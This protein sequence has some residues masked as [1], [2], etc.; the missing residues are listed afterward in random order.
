MTQ[1]PASLQK[2][3]LIAIVAPAKAIE[4]EHVL[5]AKSFFEKEGF[6]VEVS[7]NC[8]GSYN[9][10]SGDIA[11]RLR[12]FQ[13]ELDH[14]E[15]KA[16]IC[17]R[18][19]YG[20]VQLLDR[21]Q[22]AS[23]LREPKW[24]VGFS[25]VTYFHQRMQMHGI[26]SIHG[27]M[28]LNFKENSKEALSTLINCLE[29]KPSEISWERNSYNR[30]G[31]TSGKLVG[32]NLS[33]LYALLGTDDQINF[34]NTILYIEDVGEPI[35]AIDRM[36]Y[37]FS[38]AGV[39]DK[40]NGLVVGGMTSLSDT[41]VPYGNAY[42]EVVLSHFEYRKIPIAFDLPAGHIDDNRALV[43][44]KEARLDAGKDDCLLSF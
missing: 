37:A 17:A 9:Y 30:I 41:A 3:D 24:I 1:I 44:G 19:G 15:V 7:D 5:F 34:D 23:Q 4:S 18:G 11:H 35:Y 40:I 14:P 36:F 10:F 20:C 6:R 39:L 2:G 42:E 28:P 22:W 25:D 33:I 38:K 43:L 32:G 29:G 21:I 8:L 27:T 13:S 31:E 16:I 26:A 12:D